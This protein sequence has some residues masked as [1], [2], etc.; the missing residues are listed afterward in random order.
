[1]DGQGCSD[2][3]NSYREMSAYYLEIGVAKD[4]AK[5]AEV[6]ERFDL[7][8]DDFIEGFPDLAKKVQELPDGPSLS[9]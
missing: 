3:L 8:G 1:M 9:D 4:Q 5:V 2:H 7:P 6:L